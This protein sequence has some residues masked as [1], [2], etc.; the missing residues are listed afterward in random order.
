MAPRA[1]TRKD[2]A[3]AAPPRSFTLGHWMAKLGVTDQDL[4]DMLGVDRVT[5]WRYQ[6]GGVSLPGG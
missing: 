1:K 2:K 3:A 6:T 4:A 5:I